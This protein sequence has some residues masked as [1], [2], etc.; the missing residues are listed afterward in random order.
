MCL[1]TIDRALALLREKNTGVTPDGKTFGEVT[2]H[3][4]FGG[5]ET[6]FL[7]SNGDITIIGDKEKP[8][9]DLPT[10]SSRTSTTVYR[11]GSAAGATGPTGFLPPGA[12][13]ASTKCFSPRRRFKCFSPR[14]RFNTLA[15]PA[16]PPPPP[17]R[18]ASQ[19]RIHGQ[20]PC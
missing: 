9:H 16:P 14:R 4:F 1:Q 13:L 10:G 15:P 2:D 8:K 7:A 6:C 19:G 17:C 3:F 5:D 18:E 11:V 12:L 20:V